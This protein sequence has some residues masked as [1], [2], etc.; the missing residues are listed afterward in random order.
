MD[1]A[2]KLFQTSELLNHILFIGVNWLELFLLFLSLFKNDEEFLLIIW[3]V[4]RRYYL[5]IFEALF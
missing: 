2:E 3:N 1:N 4:N 5:P